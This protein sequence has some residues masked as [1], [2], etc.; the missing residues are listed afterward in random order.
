[1]GEGIVVRVGPNAATVLMTHA[2]REIFVG[3]YIEIE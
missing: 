1:M 2:R 3:D